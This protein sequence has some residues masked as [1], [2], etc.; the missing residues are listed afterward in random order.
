MYK[1]LFE[2]KIYSKLDLW[3]LEEW[4]YNMYSTKTWMNEKYEEI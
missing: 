3:V 4:G 1:P 2:D